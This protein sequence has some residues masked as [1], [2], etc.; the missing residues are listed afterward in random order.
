MES[1]SRLSELFQ[2]GL[3]VEIFGLT[4]RG[5]VR[6]VLFK[7]LSGVILCKGVQLS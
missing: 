5:S 1:G 6:V 7:M 3:F 2:Q 4:N